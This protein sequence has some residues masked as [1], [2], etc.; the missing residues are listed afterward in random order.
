M[1]VRRGPGADG[2]AA[3][4]DVDSVLPS[5]RR[6]PVEVLVSAMVTCDTTWFHACCR[7]GGWALATHHKNYYRTMA[8]RACRQSPQEDR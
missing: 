7:W 4:L 6:H 1:E 5:Q 3:P 8:E 2:D